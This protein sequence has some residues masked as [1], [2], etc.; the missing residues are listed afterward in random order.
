M[1]DSKIEKAQATCITRCLDWM[2][3][4]RCNNRAMYRG[5]VRL[6]NLS[7]VEQNSISFISARWRDVGR[8]WEVIQFR[9]RLERAL[10][11]VCVNSAPVMEDLIQSQAVRAA[12]PTG[13]FL[14]LRRTRIYPRLCQSRTNLCVP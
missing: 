12:L 9:R 1:A 8:R 11:S 14:A 10:S 3:L 4:R 2:R 5:C 6:R 13:R 7:V